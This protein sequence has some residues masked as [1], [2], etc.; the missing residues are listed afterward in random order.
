MIHMIDS[1]S[2]FPV[3][4]LFVAALA[5]LAALAL[6]GPGGGALAGPASADAAQCKGASNSPRR[7]SAKRASNLVVCLVNK[8]RGERNLRRLSQRKD[9][10]RAASGHTK[11]MKRADCFA[12][13]CP[14]EPDLPGRLTRSDYLPCNCNWSA[15][16]N[17]AWGGGSSEGS[18]RAVVKAFMKSSTHRAEILNAGFE[19]I[20][21][22]FRHGSPFSSGKKRGTYTLDFGAK[23]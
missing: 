17:L 13:T 22:G 11:Q 6:L 23:R 7:L 14:G 2:P 15:G 9:L 18:P 21:V 20:G 10:R 5:G 19:D 4:L 3:P 1:R 16:E 8:E 12:H